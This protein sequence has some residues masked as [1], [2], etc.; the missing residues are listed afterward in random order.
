MIIEY[1][2]GFRIVVLTADDLPVGVKFKV[3][4]TQCD[5]KDY[6]GPYGNG[7]GFGEY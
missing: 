6:I 4:S 3:I 1:E 2:D 5:E 7:V